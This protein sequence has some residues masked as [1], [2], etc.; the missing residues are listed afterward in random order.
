MRTV[1]V[2]VLITNIAFPQGLKDYYKSYFPI[3]VSVSPQSLTDEEGELIRQQFNSLTAENAMKMGPIHPEETRY[4]WEGADKIVAFAQANNMKMRG[5]CL[6]W[7]RQTPDWI[8]KDKDGKEATKD[9]LL[10]RL[11]DHIYSVVGR[12]KGK[13]YAWDVVNEVIS[14]TDDEFYRQSPWFRICGEDFITKAFQ[15][16]HEAD[17]EAILFYNDYN[18][19]SVSKREKIYKMILKLIDAGVPIGGIGIQGHWSIVTDLVGIQE[20]ISLFIQFHL[21]IQVTELDISIYPKKTDPQTAYTAEIEQKQTALYRQVFEFFRSNKKFITGVTFWNVS[22]KH[23]WLDNFPVKDR[24]N[25]PLLFDQ[26]L[27]PKKAF[28]EVVKTTD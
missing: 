26:Q 2:L 23:S 14:D 28:W 8:F 21:P 20:S 7:H 27:K 5:H 6:V 10:Q 17:P 15:Y 12:Y 9:V 24:K 13:I 3:G 25:Y 1:F 16:A 18:T 22:D 4:N 11:K 19:E